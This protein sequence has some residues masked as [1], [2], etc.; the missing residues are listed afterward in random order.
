MSRSFVRAGRRDWP[1]SHIDTDSEIG[2]CTVRDDIANNLLHAADQASARVLVNW[3][4][5]AA[6]LTPGN[7]PDSIA[8]SASDDWY[9]WATFGPFHVSTMERAGERVAYPL[10][11]AL[12]AAASDV[13]TV[14]FAVV[15]RPVGEA[16]VGGD[17]VALEDA[18]FVA[19]SDCERFSTASTTNAWLTPEGTGKITIAR[20]TIDAAT[21]T[22]VTLD[23]PAGNAV[24]VTTTEVEIHVYALC[25]DDATG[26]VYGL[27]VAEVYEP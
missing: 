16:V 4:A 18:Y 11:V 2:P 24:N 13:F 8:T 9:L 21:G 27:H 20:P 19:G 23:E 17:G 1:A 12:A 26:I 22:R 6:S 25:N 15:V 10:R 3:V 5:V 7:A 14:K